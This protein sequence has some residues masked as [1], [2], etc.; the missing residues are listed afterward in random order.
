MW[1]YTSAAAGALLLFIINLIIIRLSRAESNKDI[2]FRNS[3]QRVHLNTRLLISWTNRSSPCCICRIFSLEFVFKEMFPSFFVCGMIPSILVLIHHQKKSQ[4]V[5]ATSCAVQR[6][7]GPGVHTA[8]QLLRLAVA[9]EFSSWAN[10]SNYDIHNVFALV[11]DLDS[12]LLLL[13]LLLVLWALMVM[14]IN[15]GGSVGICVL[16][17]VATATR[18]KHE[19][20]HHWSVTAAASTSPQVKQTRRHDSLDTLRMNDN[21]SRVRRRRL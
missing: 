8:E 9:M 16:I 13:C 14:V 21:T 1:W 15:W 3:I 19:H 12:I 18:F 20:Y 5:T 6:W 11:A 17:P 10:N 4:W 2:L 7:V